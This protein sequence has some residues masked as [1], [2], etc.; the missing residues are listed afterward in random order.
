MTLEDQ[1]IRLRRLIEKSAADG[2]LLF[3]QVEELL[4]EGFAGGRELDDLLFAIESAGVEILDEPKA[5][6]DGAADTVVRDY[7]DDPV[8]VYTREVC[9]VA[10]LSRDQE[11]AL[12]KQLQSDEPAAERAK[13][14]LVEPN[15]RMV[16]SIAQRH[17]DRGVHVL[18]LVIQ[19]NQGLMD[20]LAH[21][22]GQRGYRF[23]SY[24]IWWVRRRI[25]LVI[26]S[27]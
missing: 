24:A 5:G 6:W 18:D 20:A 14:D 2:Y 3:D 27:A 4:P 11:L 15:L 23:S 22:D 25:H 7:T 10:A 26:P 8:Q 17:A 9:N 19:G 21:F 12:A 13:Q 16:V 1:A